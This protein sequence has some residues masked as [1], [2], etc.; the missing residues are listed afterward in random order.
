MQ[1]VGQQLGEGLMFAFQGA[2][3]ETIPTLLDSIWKHLRDGLVN[4]FNNL[5][6]F[7]QQN[8]TPKNFPMFAL[9]AGLLAQLAASPVLGFLTRLG[10]LLGSVTGATG[11]LLPGII[12]L[13]SLVG[14]FSLIGGAIILIFMNWETIVATL[15]PLVE[16]LAETLRIFAMNVLGN[17]IE[18]LGGTEVAIQK[19]SDMFGA[20][21]TIIADLG[22]VFSA[23]LT[24]GGLGDL[25]SAIG[26][27]FSQAIQAIPTGGISAAVST[28]FS[29]VFSNLEG[30]NIGTALNT[31]FNNAIS[32]LRDNILPTLTAIFSGV[33]QSLVNLVPPGV[34]EAIT[35]VADQIKAFFEQGR[36][37]GELALLFQ[38]LGKTM[39]ELG[40]IFG[41]IVIVALAA[42]AD[43]VLSLLQTLGDILPYIEGILAGVI[44]TVRGVIMT[45]E[46]I[47]QVII[48]IF[49]LLTGKTDEANAMLATALGNIAGG[50]TT[51]F[52]GI[53][54]IV[55]NALAG[56]VAAVISF[57]SHLFENV[58]LVTGIMGAEPIKWIQSIHQFRIDALAA[59]QQFA[60]DFRQFVVDLVNSVIGFFINLKEQLV[61]GSII[62]EMVTAIL[63]VILGLRDQFIAYIE[64]L[65]I[66]VLSYAI[67][68]LEVGTAFVSNI[69]KGI[70]TAWQGLVDF[71]T[72]KVDALF[73][74]ILD[75]MS[76]IPGMLDPG[77]LQKAGANM[78]DGVKTGIEG[79]WG[80]VINA[81]SNQTQE[82]QEPVEATKTGIL[83]I[84]QGLQSDLVGN[85][86][87]P[88]TTLAIVNSFSM[89]NTTLQNGLRTFINYA[90]NLWRNFTN[91][92]MQLWQVMVSTIISL[93]Q[94][95]ED[96]LTSILERIVSLFDDWKKA[97]DD[98]LESLDKLPE[99]LIQ[100][101]ETE[102]QIRKL[103]EA[104][105]NFADEVQEVRDQVERLIEGLKRLQ[106]LGGG[107]NVT[108]GGGPTGYQHGAWRIPH[109]GIA[110]L[111]EGETVLPSS[112]ATNF[113]ALMNAISRTGIN[114]INLGLPTMGTP[115]LAM[116][117][118]G[119]N[120][121]TFEAGAFAGAFPS[122]RDGRDAS[123]FL[124]QL[125]QLTSRGS[126][127]GKVVG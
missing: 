69:Q 77:Q 85:S 57:V 95:M 17:V 54:L 63:T 81:F 53:V 14:R 117:S 87:I 116:Q 66:S 24:G 80:S 96:V 51:A 55:E 108:M 6:T 118:P 20:V 115:A 27:A 83:G 75:V 44:R 64:E 19:V 1:E 4:I 25:A 67:R 16:R 94:Q 45:I 107:F 56:V 2:I 68:F 31:L 46:G 7:V 71:V 48:G 52:S 127:R 38:E 84:F 91:Q 21:Q 120:Q 82:L 40:K 112:I 5:K 86:I 13:V 32:G 47:A 93:A 74:P 23:L 8:V 97:V 109:T 106:D 121:Y 123:S 101:G 26:S 3:P 78:V 105:T 59:I 124:E 72:G 11:G 37:G 43:V 99:V 9:L 89:M 22:N 113:R 102:P 88:D 104:F 76:K 110:M 90:L 35:Q 34:V 119:N 10:G 28:F 111:H 73:G 50:F 103:V 62:P 126:L 36:L 29:S 12:R 30:T 98:L 61:G 58:N 60:N 79:T 33:G 70:E 39:Y 18:K 49:L 42:V 100:I 114:G 65:V 122:V 92:M 15:T 41:P 125:D